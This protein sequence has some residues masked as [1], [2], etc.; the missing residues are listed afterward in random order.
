VF[1]FVCACGWVVC[2]VFVVCCV[3]VWEC[4][5][6]RVWCVCFR[7]GGVGCVCV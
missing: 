5:C 3:F 4:V 6:V 7:V 1:V 2:E